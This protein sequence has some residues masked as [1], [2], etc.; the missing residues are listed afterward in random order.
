MKQFFT[1]KTL[2]F[3][4]CAVLLLVSKLK[5][6]QLSSLSGQKEV[7]TA[8][9]DSIAEIKIAKN[10]QRETNKVNTWS[11]IRRLWGYS[12]ADFY[13][14]A[15]SDV[16]NRGPET[17]YNNILTDRNAFQFRRLYLGYDYDISQ[18]FTAE[19]LLASEPSA[20]TGINNNTTNP[21]GNIVVD[22]KMIFFIKNFNLR[23]RNLWKGTD[24]VFGELST[25]GFALNELGTNAPTSL[26]ESAWGYR[27]IEKTFT[28]FH[29]TNSYDVGLSLQGTFDPSVKNYGYVLMVGNNAGAN[30][31]Y[32]IYYGDVWAK[33]L[34]N[35]N[36]YVDLYADY[37]QTSSITSI[38]GSQYNNIFKAFVSYNTHKL[39]VG[40]EAYTQKLNNAVFNTST[41]LNENAT[42]NAFSL[43]VKGAI[44]SVTDPKTVKTLTKL[45]FFARYDVYNPD[46]KYNTSSSYTTNP[47]GFSAYTPVNKEQFIT[48]GLDFIPEPITAG[49]IH[50]EPNIWYVKYQDQRNA[51]V[52]GYVPTDHT[53]VYRMTVFFT[54]GK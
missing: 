10:T 4:M 49:R 5:A 24:L 3:V 7:K 36:L 45:G 26:S 40:A 14:V 52:A 38:V 27:S 18:H 19:V 15:H 32:K 53:L 17:V 37:A 33:F 43:W 25:P 39:S 35:K 9:V 2:L 8:N 44:L 46:T 29:K 21:N 12:F 22:T 20:N 6:Q 54:F 30:S 51:T 1:K 47:G 41:S 16:A 11:P 48:I 28:D 23:Y 13:Y 31:G 50:I 34:T 42:V